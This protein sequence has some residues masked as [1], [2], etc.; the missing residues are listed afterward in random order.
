MKFN[1]QDNL[2]KAATKLLNSRRMFDQLKE[3]GNRNNYPAKVKKLEERIKSEIELW[4]RKGPS[5]RLVDL[6]KDMS[7]IEKQKGDPFFDKEKIDQLT[8]KYSISYE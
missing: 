2:E 7:F 3:L 5:A 6:Q 4:E 1:K 8:N